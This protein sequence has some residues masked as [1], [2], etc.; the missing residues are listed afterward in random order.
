MSRSVLSPVSAGTGEQGS[1]GEACFGCFCP[2]NTQRA[3]TRYV[4]SVCDN[5]S[6]AARAVRRERARP[7]ARHYTR[8]RELS[9]ERRRERAELSSA[10]TNA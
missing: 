2:L 8:R 1:T 10:M 3:R 9:R 7:E 5:L 4:Y 6:D